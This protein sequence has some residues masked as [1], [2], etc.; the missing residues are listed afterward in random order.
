MGT[1]SAS[2]SATVSRR[3]VTGGEGYHGRVNDERDGLARE[4]RDASRGS[5]VKLAAEVLSRLLGLATTL[6]LIRGLGPSD[7]GAF[8]KLSLYA[9]LLGELAE[10]G[11]Q[12]LAS[13][14]LVAGSLSLGALVRAR[15]VLV[16]LLG[17]A[18]LGC[19]GLAPVLSP[20]V[21][22][23]ALSG[24]GEFLGVALRC[25]GRRVAEALVLLCLRGFGLV[26]AALVLGMGSGLATLAWSL[27]LSTLPSLLLGAVL[28]RR[29]PAGPAGVDAGVGQVMREALPLAL[30]GGLVLLSP[31]VEFLVL[32]LL[33]GDRETGLFLAALRV[34]EFLNVVP[35][36]VSA[37]AMPGLTREAVRGHG[38]VRSRTAW[39][40]AFLAAPA[41][42]GLGLVAPA[43]ARLLL[44]G[45]QDAAAYA[46]TA[47]PLRLLSLALPALFVNSLLLCALVAASRAAWLPR[48]TLVRVLA[49]FAMAVPLVSAHGG[50]GAAAGIVVAE[51]L[52]ALLAA[53]ACRAASFEVELGRPLAW[54]LAATI[55]M[56]LAIFPV[57]DDLWLALPLGAAVQ[58][59]AVAAA[60]KIGS[61][62]KSADDLLYP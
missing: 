59:V 30:H 19:V 10:L 3:E 15:L 38:P 45:G 13:R 60:R 31:R 20:L 16:A 47:A 9:L 52:L 12:T 42:V 54:A 51:W 56:A 39:T 58:A 33:R 43:V 24:W 21:L 55:P 26:A 11:L 37:G 41:A 27:V 17:G 5:A 25:R 44:G 29:A 62:R 8:G 50:M 61:G 1:A 57:R 14:A 40:L 35:A 28:L 46:G 32:S 7:F 18:A 23:F 6:L 53:R 49:A 2:A 34:Y 48:L 22:W 4:A 36:A